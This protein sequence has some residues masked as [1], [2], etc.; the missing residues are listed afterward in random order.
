MPATR[1]RYGSIHLS[2]ETAAMSKSHEMHKESKKKAQK[3]A[4]EKRQAKRIKKS[5][6]TLLGSH[7]ATP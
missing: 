6:T 2:R 1:I 4:D 7:S 3:T 5:G